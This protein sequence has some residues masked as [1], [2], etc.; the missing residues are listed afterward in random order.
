[1]VERA[2]EAE[3]PDALVDRTW[4]VARALGDTR[5]ALHGTCVLALR[6]LARLW[7]AWAFLG[8]TYG[9]EE[10]ARVRSAHGAAYAPRTGWR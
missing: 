1:M 4:L 7:A 8:C 6:R 3:R 2:D 5:S 10:M 9:P